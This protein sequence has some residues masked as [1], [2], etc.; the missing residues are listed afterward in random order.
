MAFIPKRYDSGKLTK[1]LRLVN[2]QT[3][4]KGDALEDKNDG[5]F[6]RWGTSVSPTSVQYVA[7][8]ALVGTSANEHVLAVRTQGVEFEADTNANPAQTDVGTTA[9]MTNHN[10]LNES[11]SSNDVFFITRIKGAVGDKL[12]R[13][14]FVS[15]KA[16]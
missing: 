8:E 15:D 5:F 14:F 10:T 9:D 12:V 13:G 11:A 1:D 2:G 3:V 16:T 6:Q 4:A 7:M